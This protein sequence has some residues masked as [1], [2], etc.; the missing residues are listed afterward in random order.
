MNALKTKLLGE[1]KCNNHG[2]PHVASSFHHLPPLLFIEPYLV[3]ESKTMSIPQHLLHFTIELD[4]FIL[5]YVL[6]SI[7]YV[8][9]NHFDADLLLLQPSTHLNSNGVCKI[10]Q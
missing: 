8:S 6:V 7:L 3:E 1:F 5:E 9:N 10:L 4:G 2:G